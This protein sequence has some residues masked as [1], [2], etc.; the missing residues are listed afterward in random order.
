MLLPGFRSGASIPE[1]PVIKSFNFKLYYT[2]GGD[3]LARDLITQAETHLE[4][5]ENFLGTRLVEQIDIFLSE[6]PHSSYATALQRNGR[7]NLDNSSVYLT[8]AGSTQSVLFT[9]REQLARILIQDMLYGNT[10]KERLKNSR[11]INVPNWYIPGLARY[12]AGVQLPDISWMSDYFEGKLKLNLN[13]SDEQELAE[14]GHA[15]FIHISDSFG[16]GKLR[17]L[18][19]YTKLSGKTEFAFQ[20]VFN[21]SLSEVLSQWYKISK[22][23]YLSNELKRLPNEPEPVAQKIRES[24]ILDMQFDQMGE[25]IDFLCKVKGGVEIWRYHIASRTTVNIYRYT[26]VE[27]VSGWQLS[28][29]GSY[30]F[31][32]QS[33]GI[34]SRIIRIEKG[35]SAFLKEL[36]FA[37]IH[38]LKRHPRSGIVFIG[39]SRYRQQIFQFIP[40]SLLLKP[41][42]NIEEEEE[43]GF[44]FVGQTGYIITYVNQSFQIKQP[45]TGT[46]L[47]RSASP[48]RS[49]NTYLYPYLS[50]IQTHPSGNFGMIINPEDTTKQFRVTNYNRSILFYDFNESG[51]RVLEGIKY[52]KLN[53]VVVSEAGLQH[54]D[55][56]TTPPAIVHHDSLS[57][58][59]DTLKSGN[60]GYFFITGFETPAFDQ[61]EPVKKAI[62]LTPPLKLKYY[63]VKASE[64]KTDF[65]SLGFTNSVFNTTE[66]AHFYPIS[67]GLNNGANLYAAAGISD[68]RKRY[69]VRGT[70][71]QPVIGKGTDLDFQVVRRKGNQTLS[72]LFFNSNYQKELYNQPNRFTIRQTRLKLEQVVTH[73][74]RMQYQTGLRSDKQIALATSEKNLKSGV[75]EILQPFVL[76]GAETTPLHVQK[77][78]YR[79]QMIVTGHVQ[80]NKPVSYS[81]F[82]NNIHLK[83]RQEQVFYRIFN[84]NLEVQGSAS[85][86]KQKTIYV[87]G[88]VS[89]WLRPEFGNARIHQSS[90]HLMYASFADFPG[91]PYN[92]IAG[93]SA[94]SARATLSFPVNPLLSRQNFNQN[95][96]KFLTLKMYSNLGTAWFGSS[97]FS[98]SNPENRDVFE[99]GSM[100]LENYVAKNPLIWSVGGGLNTVFLGY[101][102]G[103]EYAL[104]FNERGRIGKFVYITLGKP[105]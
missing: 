41:L 68:I 43:T 58:P 103:L 93:T 79:Y 52:G 55:P 26:T 80:V 34:H 60:T 35:K 90:N 42:L 38:H 37:Y 92:F 22:Q 72:L 66:F 96:F 28:T 101:E 7:I 99:T 53:Y 46:V 27:P 57:T 102:M 13:L 16:V 75:K 29:L 84:L 64:F 86:G 51:K 88:G 91:L 78:N 15:V 8:Y 98:I 95:L 67:Q 74:T 39:Q 17:Q 11:E 1:V 59:A 6:V 77:R 82:N 85:V 89:N 9:L 21:K 40:D 14:F 24:E 76:M 44:A 56:L 31:L 5:M 4:A 61:T 73:R 23:T 10:I 12:V 81:G 33:N 19:F 104:G 97:P 36:P 94:S 71:R 2:E 100:T 83:I 87:L 47:Y 69:F 54:A 18:L 45:V 48:V 63:Q 65:V 32:V 50:W 70:V 3:K 105:L 49:L 62:I 25:N 20:Y 30:W